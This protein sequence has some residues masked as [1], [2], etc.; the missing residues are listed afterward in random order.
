M[1][2]PSYQAAGHL[3]KRFAEHHKETFQLPPWGAAV[4]AVTTLVFL[5]VLIFVS[6][7]PHPHQ[8]RHPNSPR[9]LA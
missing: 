5:P 4:V 1:M 7:P 6:L 9:S 8:P 2:E 3:I